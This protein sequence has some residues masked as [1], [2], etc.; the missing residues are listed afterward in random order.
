MKRSKVSVTQERASFKW[1]MTDV[2]L[3]MKLEFYYSSVVH[4]QSWVHKA[5]NTNGA[6][7]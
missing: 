2:V 7:L 5:E 3:G 4:M 6:H 1:Q